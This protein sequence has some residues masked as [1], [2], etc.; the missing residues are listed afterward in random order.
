[1]FGHKVVKGVTALQPSVDLASGYKTRVQ[2]VT[3]TF[4]QTL[5]FLLVSF[6]THFESVSSVLIFWE[7]KI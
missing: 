2:E 7:F 4:H 6:V 5:Q 1:V 3:F